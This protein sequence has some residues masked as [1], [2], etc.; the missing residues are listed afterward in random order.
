[1][2]AYRQKVLRSQR[3][4][5]IRRL[6]RKIW[7]ARFERHISECYERCHDNKKMR[8]HIACQGFISLITS[9]LSGPVRCRVRLTVRMVICLST[10]DYYSCPRRT[11]AFLWRFLKQQHLAQGSNYINVS[12]IA[13]RYSRA[14][15]KFTRELDVPSS[16]EYPCLHSNANL[17]VKPDTD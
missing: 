5:L 1:M 10:P 8:Y 2:S 13:S 17:H 14:F 16:F 15:E 9:K 12:E 6:P 11:S 4:N 7:R 3:C